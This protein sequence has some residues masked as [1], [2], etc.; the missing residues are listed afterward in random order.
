MLEIKMNLTLTQKSNLAYGR[1][2]Q[3]EAHKYSIWQNYEF[4]YVNLLVPELFF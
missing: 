2:L 3:Y 1:S 4:V